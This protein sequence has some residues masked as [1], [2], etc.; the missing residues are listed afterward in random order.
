M[1]LEKAKTPKTGVFWWVEQDSNLGPALNG[2][3]QSYVDRQGEITIMIMRAS[4]NFKEAG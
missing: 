4:F 1:A 2:R 3:S